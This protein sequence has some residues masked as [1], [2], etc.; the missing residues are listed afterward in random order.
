[1]GERGIHRLSATEVREARA[2]LSDGGGLLLRVKPGGAAWAW[3]FT[4]P[5]GKRREL[6]LGVCNRQSAKLAGESLT[7]ARTLATEARL[8]LARGVDPLAQRQAQRAEHRARETESTAAAATARDVE[9]WTLARCGRD[10]HARVIEPKMTAKHAAQ[11]IASLE[12]HVPA[13][14]WHAPIVTITAPALVVALLRIKPHKRA[15]HYGSGD[16][17]GETRS[18][19]LQR[20]AAVWDDAIFH[21]RATTNAAGSAARRKIA[22]GAPKRRKGSHLALPHAEAPAIMRAIAA[23][24]GIGARALEFAVLTAAR[25]GEVLGARW[26]EIDAEAK[27]W[28]I[29][30]ERMKARRPHDVPLSV[31]ALAVLDRVRGLDA[32]LIFPGA[33]V[34]ADGA[35]RPLSNM[36][37]LSALGRLGLRQRTT[38]HGLARATFS[39]WANER[40]IARP[41]VI[42]ACLA[43]AQGDKVRAAYNRASFDEERRALL[44]AWA[45]YLHRTAAPVIELHASKAAA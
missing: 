32:E 6:G 19:I 4:A 3:R 15:R 24:E 43:H 29:P 1:M 16:R 41:D 18:R 27:L 28:R 11:W 23:A 20:L 13:A 7:L 25:T 42:E 14:L 35:A 2:D 26:R 45:A 8:M 36:A 12:N 33:A 38:A 44:D 31:Q 22:E 34:G 30:A 37:M 10:Y 39:T 40:G 9:H 17:L 5:D 21:G